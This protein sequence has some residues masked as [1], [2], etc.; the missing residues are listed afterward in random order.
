MLLFD[1]HAHIN[2]ERYDDKSRLD[3]CRKINESRDIAYVVDVGYDLTSSIIAT[4]D[5]ENN[6]WCY[7][8]VGIHPHYADDMDEETLKEIE[9]LSHLPKVVAIGEIGL[10]Y[11]YNNSEKEAQRYWFRKQIRLANRL[12]MP[13]VIHSRDADKETMDILCDEGAF[14]EERTDFF[15]KR[16]ADEKECDDARVLIHC[17]SGSS[18]MASEYVNLGATISICGP[19]TFKNNKKTQRVV[20]DLSLD[21]MLIETDSP[22]LTPEPYRGREN[23]ST[24]VK[25]V[26]EKIAELKGMTVEEVARTTLWNAKKFYNIDLY[27]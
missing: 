17:Y 19:V 9:R 13:I 25:F 23:D 5:A 10:D 22:Y 16:I 20:K 15:P 8:S 6:D 11:H 4:E 26:A 27:A 24:N 21:A 3:L 12:R 1:A 18:E 7:A 14:S 2:E